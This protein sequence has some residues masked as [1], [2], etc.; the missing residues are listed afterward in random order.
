MNSAFRVAG[1]PQFEDFSNERALPPGKPT[2]SVRPRHTADSAE[3]ADQNR[4]GH[5]GREKG[6]KAPQR[7]AARK[8]TASATAGA[9]CSFTELPSPTVPCPDAQTARAIKH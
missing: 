9:M 1:P 5:N 3:S 6:P 4:R 2:V 8:K 7:E